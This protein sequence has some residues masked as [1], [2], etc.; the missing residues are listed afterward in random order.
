MQ[1]NILLLTSG[2]PKKSSENITVRMFNKAGQH[3]FV[4]LKGFAIVH[5]DL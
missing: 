3:P 1:Q 2:R 4:L 5:E